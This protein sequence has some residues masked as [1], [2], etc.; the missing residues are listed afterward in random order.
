MHMI[1]SFS[2]KYTG[3]Y[4]KESLATIWQQIFET[5]KNMQAKTLYLS[6]FF[7]HIFI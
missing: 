2:K 7:L 1:L 6:H 4:S 5:A 3:S